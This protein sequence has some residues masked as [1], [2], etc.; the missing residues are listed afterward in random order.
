M[1]S[2]CA[3]ALNMGTDHLVTIDEPAHIILE[4][5]GKKYIRIRHVE[6][7]QGVRGRNSD[8]S[9]LLATLDWEPQTSLHDGLSNTYEWIQARVKG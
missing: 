8:N 5:A 7:P 3:E 1:R 6:G 2:D 4:L 9:K